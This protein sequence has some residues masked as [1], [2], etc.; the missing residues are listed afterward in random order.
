MAHVTPTD[1]TAAGAQHILPGTAHDGGAALL[2]NI[3]ADP[4]RPSTAQKPCD[5][6]L[7][8]DAARAQLDLI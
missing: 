3:S 1:R 6:G 8:D 7:F 4:M 5:V 2:R